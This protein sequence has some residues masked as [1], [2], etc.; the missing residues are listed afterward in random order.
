MARV[1]V[2]PTEA[3][4][5]GATLTQATFTADGISIPT[6]C[7]VLVENTSGGSSNITVQTPQ[8]VEG[9]AVAEQITA[10][11]TGTLKAYGRLKPATFARPSGGSDEGRI[12]IDSSVTTG[13]TYAVVEA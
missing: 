1:T 3:S 10:Q 4:V 2:T 13:V 5:A 6:G 9:L 8:T 11:A 7:I 12:W